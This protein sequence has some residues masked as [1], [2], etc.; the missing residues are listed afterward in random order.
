MRL[1]TPAALLEPAPAPGGAGLA[2]LVEGLGLAWTAFSLPNGLRVILHED[3]R[4]PLVRVS[5]T[6]LAGSKDEGPG[7][8]GLAHLTEHL[9]FTGT[10]GLPG[11]F[12]ARL[13]EA[14][15]ADINAVT[16]LD[17]TRFHETVPPGMLEF[18]LFAEADRMARLGAALSSEALEQQRG[19]VLQ[20]KFQRE[21]APFGRMAEAVATLVYPSSHPY[22][23]GIGGS[24]RDLR[25]TG[26][27]QV[28]AWLN[29][30]YTPSNAILVLA[31]HFDT[32][33]AKAWI[34]RHFGGLP[35]GPPLLRRLRE[36]PP[37]SGAQALLDERGITAPRLVLVWP[38][39]QS[40][41]AE[42]P[43]LVLGAILLGGGRTGHLHKSLV[44][45]G[46]NEGQKLISAVR[47][48]LTQHLLCGEFR[49]EAD[50]APGASFDEAESVVARAIEGFLAHPPGAE[51]VALA[52]GELLTGLLRSLQDISAQ[53]EL[54]ASGAAATGDPGA[55]LTT[56]R[57]L[58]AATPA[59]IQTAVRLITRAAPAVLRMRPFT[60]AATGAAVPDSAAPAPLPVIAV[61]SPSAPP[62]TPVRS[63]A[64]D[65]GLRLIHIQ[66]SGDPGFHLRLHLARGTADGD[67]A[68]SG[69]ALLLA[70]QARL[71]AGRHP[72]PEF[73]AALR[74]AGLNLSMAAEPAAFVIH[75]SGL[76][77]ALEAG[78]ATLEDLVLRPVF[79]QAALAEALAS[80]RERI[81]RAGLDAGEKAWRRLTALLYGPRH[82]LARP[83]EARA[84]EAL[85]PAILQARHA[86]IFNPACATLMIAGAVDAGQALALAEPLRPWAGG[87]ALSGTGFFPPAR[88]RA[89]VL[90]VLPE[91]GL[92]QVHLLAGCR[93]EAA[94]EGAPL[95]EAVILHALA[96]SPAARLNVALRDTR[97]WTYGVR[98]G[99]ADPLRPDCARLFHL[100]AALAREHAADAL[101][102]IQEIIAA[103]AGTSPITQAEIEAFQRRAL[104]HLAALQHDTGAL[105]REL[106][107]QL[108]RG[109]TLGDWAPRAAAIRDISLAGVRQA[110]GKLLDARSFCW[111]LRGEPEMLYAQ[112]AARGLHL[113][114]VP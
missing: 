62:A 49:I 59:A 88:G 70:D 33:T 64:F 71:G 80:L 58:A 4:S 29:H 2:P 17:E 18:T 67:E 19:I 84:L 22:H 105:L 68:W 6:Y 45:A 86:E 83:T 72:G 99:I 36:V 21:E 76:D 94:P 93:L 1:V 92:Q 95:E 41:A 65:N 113:T 103:V 102:E 39:P 55:Y 81:A 104:L 107:P 75:L 63:V 61:Q 48:G 37:P 13:Q 87:R 110:A 24:E 42:V 60:H 77:P 40:S 51:D 31:G 54:L 53:A 73:A 50:L 38:T 34:A 30:F 100:N 96:G 7:Q 106:D 82:P 35:A 3:H 89:G 52:R 26:V 78:F 8:T 57:R 10:A 11:A 74:R 14:G 101:G 32:A 15:A 5:L 108:R 111:T 79:P 43:H 27:A 114:M 69:A 44:D 9:M 16:S 97:H 28:Q 47:A 85:T 20:E 56:A 46:G 25:G 91:P 109:E 90:S 12:G 98:S 112:V 23:H 66:R